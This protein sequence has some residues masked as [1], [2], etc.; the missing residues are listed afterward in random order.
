MTGHH[1]TAGC[2]VFVGTSG[3]ERLPAGVRSAVHRVANEM[4]TWSE[5]ALTSSDQAQDRHPAEFGTFATW[6]RADP[7]VRSR[8][9]GANRVS[10]VRSGDA[11]VAWEAP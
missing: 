2:P 8:W 11:F 3:R 9:H 10:R 4:A 7:V 6:S 5:M 1:T